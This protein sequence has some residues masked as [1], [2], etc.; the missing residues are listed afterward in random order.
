MDEI[1]RLRLEI[2]VLVLAV[3]AAWMFGIS[4][5]NIEVIV[6]KFLVFC[7]AVIVVHSSRR[8]LF[9]YLDFGQVLLGEGRWTKTPA[10]VRASIVLGVFLY[11]AV[12]IYALTQAI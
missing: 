5:S 9:P 2:A 10:N 8:M 11:Y 3:F 6:F 12:L 4:R 7:P 1:K